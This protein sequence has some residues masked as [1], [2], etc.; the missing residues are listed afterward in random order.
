MQPGDAGDDERVWSYV[1]FFPYFFPRVL[2]LER[3]EVY[4]VVDKADA[5]FGDL[6]DGFKPLSGSDRIDNEKIA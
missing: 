5:V 4:P 6:F 1:K 3:A 2:C